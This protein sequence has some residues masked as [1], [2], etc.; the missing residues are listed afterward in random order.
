MDG[1]APSFCSQ[2]S[3][4]SVCWSRDPDTGKRL[5]TFFWD[6]SVKQLSL[7]PLGH[8]LNDQVID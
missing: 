3:Q 2:N 1:L 8:I 6:V 4:G 7:E 5:K